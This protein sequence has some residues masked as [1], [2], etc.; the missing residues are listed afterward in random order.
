M[1][2]D[3]VSQKYAGLVLVGGLGTRL[4]SVINEIP[5]PMAP[6]N[7]RP[8]LEFILDKYVEAGFTD[9]WLATGYKSSVIEKHFGNAYSGLAIHYARETTPLGT[10]GAIIQATKEIRKFY[11]AVICSNGDTHST[12]NIN[13][14]INAHQGAPNNVVM[15]T[16]TINKNERY[17]SI[18]KDGDLVLELGQDHDTK[19]EPEINA[20]T[21]AF[22]CSTL[23][24][25]FD[26]ATF[27]SFEEDIL[28]QFAK[29]NSLQ[30]HLER[31][32]NFI[33]IGIPHDYARFKS[34]I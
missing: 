12:A 19:A 1:H 6:I 23:L 3:N 29:T 20:G 32:I 5:K 26:E 17:L 27:S 21:Y 15:L 9:I 14:L 25:Q 11:K 10:G 18:A 16:T 7:N 34:S 8:F 22:E 30:A 33:D 2:G 4:R 24:D 28:P 13:A 31:D